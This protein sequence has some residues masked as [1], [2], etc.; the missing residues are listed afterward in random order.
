MRLAEIAINNFCSCPALTIP[1]GQFNP[2]VGYNN[3]GKSNILRAV[4]WL[5]R[6]SVLP[7]HMFNDVTQSVTVEGEIDGVNMTLLP[8]NQQA[9]VAPYVLN[10]RLRFRRRQDNPGASATQLRIDV[11]DHQTA[12]WK[13]NPT[14][15]D[16]AIA[17][18]FPEPLY[19]GAM[20]DAGEDVAK[21]GAKNTIGLLLKYVLEAVRN[22]NAVA[23]AAIQQALQ[24]VG[25]HLNGPQRVQELVQ[26]EASATQAIASFFPDLSLHVDIATPQ[27]EDLFK[28]A[29]VSLCDQPGSPRPFASFG[30]G[31]QRSAH[32]ALIKL[33]A[34]Q[35]RVGAPA[36]GTIVLLVDEP[37]LYLH[38]QAI[39]IL[40]ESFKSLSHQGFQVVFSTHSPLLIGE[41][42]VLDTSVI[43]KNAG[44]TV[45]RQK[46][47]TAAQ[48]IGAHTHQASVIFSLQNASYLLFSEKVVLVEGKTEKMILP[49]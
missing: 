25:V 44:A 24:N 29:A 27:L 28:G 26:F 1:L 12:S 47:S 36:A 49:A 35:T 11:F 30:H 18:L 45:V 16:N 14:G 39:E 9:Q 5:L 19:I 42:D 13:Q 38:P 7:P 48:T 8:P 46:L 22:N 20:E 43:Y 3:S 23:L 15:L 34:D 32:M 41:R 17:V 21:F 40:R 6:K 31:A 37:E 10:G 33:L 4:N 2:M